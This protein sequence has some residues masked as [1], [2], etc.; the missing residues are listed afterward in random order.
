[1]ARIDGWRGARV[2][3]TVRSAPSAVRLA[4]PLTDAAVEDA[5]LDH[6]DQVADQGVLVAARRRALQVRH[7]VVRDRVVDVER[8]LAAAL[9]GQEDEEDVLQLAAEDQRVEQQ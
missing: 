4:S 2:R 6:R 7:L 5:I 9:A 3:A 1:M 8:S